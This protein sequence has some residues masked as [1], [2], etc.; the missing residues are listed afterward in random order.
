MKF[1]LFS[2][3]VLFGAVQ[4]LL[5]AL[6]LFFSMSA[7]KVQKNLLAFFMLILAYNG[8]ETSGWS[9]SFSNR[10]VFFDL[11]NFTLIFSLGPTLFLYIRSF[12]KKIIRKNLIHFS[13]TGILFVTRLLYLVYYILSAYRI[14]PIINYNLIENWRWIILEPLTAVVFTV[15]LFFSF[16][17][18]RKINNR[19]GQFSPE[20]FA[21]VQRWLKIFLSCMA[22]ITVL[23]IG[24]LLA[25]RFFTISNGHQYYITE[26]LLAVFIYW[27]GLMGYQRIKFIY[28][29]QQP[30]P[31]YLDTIADEE[32]VA[33]E[34][35]LEYTMKIDKLYLN[36]ELTVAGLAKHTGFNVKL[37]SAVLNQRLKKRFND[38]VNEYRLQEFKERATKTN[39]QHLTISGLAAECGFN[40][41]ASFQRIFKQ[42]IGISPSEYLKNSASLS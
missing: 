5:I 38:L 42:R 36:P 11:F 4:G 14:V 34:R 22:A 41:Q 9:T 3:I 13:F 30:G 37:I 27:T 10:F 20:H 21:I 33:C 19:E 25:A 18:F 2:I 17:E 7:N 24:S 8:F 29:D 39:W 23:W 16:K 26:V 6:Y 40:S 12:H 28:I 15:Y 32:I 31:G 1:D 35:S